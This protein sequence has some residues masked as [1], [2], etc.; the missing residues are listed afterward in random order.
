MAGLSTIRHRLLSGDF[1]GL[2]LGCIVV[3]HPGD[4]QGSGRQFSVRAQAQLDKG[5]R[6]RN[7]LRLPA[8]VTLHLLHSSFAGIV[9]VTAGLAKVAGLYKRTLDLHG[10]RVIDSALVRGF[11]GLGDFVPGSGGASP[12]AG[13]LRRQRGQ[14]DRG[15]GQD[16]G[17]K[18]EEER[19]A[20][21]NNNG[22]RIV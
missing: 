8:I 6:V 13:R 11:V 19:I 17:R 7:D 2:I 4:G 9:P 18:G 22:I 12:N 16:C 1:F 3:C 10:A 21:L 5:T 20:N 15:G 14:Q